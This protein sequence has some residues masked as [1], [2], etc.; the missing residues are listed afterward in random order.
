VEALAQAGDVN[1]LAS[2]DSS[3]LVRPNDEGA[4]VYAVRYNDIVRSGDPTTNY[5][6][7]PGDV[8]YVPPG[9]MARIGFGIQSMFYPIQAI[10]GLG[11][12]WAVSP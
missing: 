3:H 4:G 1:V 9:R 11:G 7:Q 6:L 12:R 8:I 2:A 10:F 5:E